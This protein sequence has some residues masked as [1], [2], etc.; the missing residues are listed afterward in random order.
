[1]R[2]RDGEVLQREGNPQ[3]RAMF[4]PR[5]PR[6][7]SSAE[8][9]GARN[10]GQWISNVQLLRAVS[11]LQNATW[12]LRKVSGRRTQGPCIEVHLR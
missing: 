5:A 1:L 12:P 9:V 8:S 2:P 6:A 4:A 7:Q 10:P 11:R 3:K